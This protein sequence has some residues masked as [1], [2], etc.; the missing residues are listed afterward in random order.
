MTSVVAWEVADGAEDVMYFLLRIGALAAVFVGTTVALRA[1]GAWDEAVSA[2]IFSAMLS[3]GLTLAPV[4]VLVL[5]HPP[6]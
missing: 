6:S 1:G 4:I 2:G 3:F 5:L